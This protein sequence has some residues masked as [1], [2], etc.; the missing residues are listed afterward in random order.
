VRTRPNESFQKE[1]FRDSFRNEKEK[2]KEDS[3]KEKTNYSKYKDNTYKIYEE[4]IKIIPILVMLEDRYIL[5][6]AIAEVSREREELIKKLQKW[7]DDFKELTLAYDELAVIHGETKA[8][9]DEL[10]ESI[11][12]H[13]LGVND[14]IRKYIFGTGKK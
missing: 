11:S 14:A 5:K 13:G 10:K 1:K 4:L 12:I 8:E 3:E 6:K 9:R 7:S 2:G